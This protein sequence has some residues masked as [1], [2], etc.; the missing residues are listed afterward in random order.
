MVWPYYMYCM[1]H[2]YVL[3]LQYGSVRAQGCSVRVQVITIQSHYYSA[4]LNS[5]NCKSICFLL[6]VYTSL[7]ISELGDFN[8]VLQNLEV[9][10]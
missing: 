2:M 1:Y 8:Y 4:Y 6:I 9:K 7:L 5:S 10:N 3:Y